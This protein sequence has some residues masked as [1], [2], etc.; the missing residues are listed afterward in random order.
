[1]SD[2]SA[3]L[4]PWQQELWVDDT[5]FQVVAAGRRRGKSRYAAWKLI[6]NALSDKPGQ[7]DITEQPLDGGLEEV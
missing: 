2:L 7:V 1:M 5:R 3:E 4:L 6:I